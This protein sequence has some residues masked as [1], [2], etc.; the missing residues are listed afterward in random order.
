VKAG[1]APVPPTAD[2]ARPGTEN[3]AQPDA[4]RSRSGAGVDSTSVQRF[5]LY[6]RV[7][8]VEQTQNLSL[9][10]QARACRDHCARDL[11]LEFRSVDARPGI[12]HC[13]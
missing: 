5:S 11:A 9:P 1:V 8:T 12:D 7:S 13:R 4:V 10:I 2:S 3:Q 6:C